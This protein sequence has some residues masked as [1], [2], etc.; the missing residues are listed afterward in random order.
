MLNRFY[1][2]LQNSRNWWHYLERTW[3]IS[4][5][6]NIT[7][8]DQRLR[9]HLIDDDRLLIM[10]AIPEYAGWLTQEAWEWLEERNQAGEFYN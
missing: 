9:Q 2:E 3:L 7:Q 10:K 8:L 4:T 1:D 6:E 5:P